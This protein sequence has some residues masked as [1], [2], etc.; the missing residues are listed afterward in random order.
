M[1]RARATPPDESV[2]YDTSFKHDCSIHI[3]QAIYPALRWRIRWK[4][5]PWP[6]FAAIYNADTSSGI[7]DAI[8]DSPGGLP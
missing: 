4:R 3:D 5:L 8:L 6:H 7:I 2:S 1:L